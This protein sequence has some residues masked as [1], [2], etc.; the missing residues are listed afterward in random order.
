MID[1]L[2][3]LSDNTIKVLR[4]NPENFIDEVSIA[5]DETSVCLQLNLAGLGRYDLSRISS[6][7]YRRGFFETDF[8]E[9]DTSINTD[10]LKVDLGQF[11]FTEKIY[12]VNFLYLF[13]Q[14][15]PVSL[16]NI[17]H[18]HTS[19][20]HNLFIAGKVGLNIPKTF[21]SSSTAELR[22]FSLKQSTITKAICKGIGFSSDELS[23]TSYTS[24]VNDM[25][26]QEDPTSQHR[27]PSLF[28]E[29]LIKEYELRIFY[30]K[31]EF[32]SSAIFSQNDD[33]TRVDFRNYNLRRPNRCIP[34]KLP[35]E[36]QIKLQKLM[37]QLRMD[38][39]SIDMVVTKD[40]DF[41]FLEVNP[42]G[43]FKQVSH[44]CN[45]YLEKKVASYLLKGNT[46]L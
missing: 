26:F 36:I 30:I 13:L 42:T 46:V 17:F 35:D 38:T 37:E 20:L 10:Q 29:E 32:Y 7:W 34:Y 45:Y 40:H 19:K 8:T 12:L 43:Q 44:P 15:C 14:K 33:Q 5:M 6:L 41:V 11:V 27:F 39:G 9:P 22:E 21:V 25:F 4:I 18:N 24:R 2:H 23:I 3:H 1:W 31:G 28:Q 16:G